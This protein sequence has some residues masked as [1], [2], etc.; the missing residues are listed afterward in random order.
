MSESVEMRAHNHAMLATTDYLV[1]AI[2]VLDEKFGE[3]YARD[4]PGLV[5]AFIRTCAQEYQNMVGSE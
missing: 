2:R 1:R 4:N 5:A 3:G